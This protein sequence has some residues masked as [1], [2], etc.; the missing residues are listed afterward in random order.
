MK[1]NE[2]IKVGILPEL[3]GKWFSKE[4]NVSLPPSICSDVT[5]PVELDDKSNQLWCYC[6]KGEFGKMIL[7]ENNN[8]PIQWFHTCL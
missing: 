7:Y 8:C 5:T 6:K 3:V 1:A 2:L 4:Q